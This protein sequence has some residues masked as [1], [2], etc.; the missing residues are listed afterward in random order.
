MP[1]ASPASQ[2]ILVC[3]YFIYCAGRNA[4]NVINNNN[5]ANRDESKHE[6]RD[7]KPPRNIFIYIIILQNHKIKTH[8]EKEK[9]IIDYFIDSLDKFQIKYRKKPRKVDWTHGILGRNYLG[10]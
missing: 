2:S 8:K 4:T 9:I 5:V 1:E 6:L 10:L 3:F 7:K